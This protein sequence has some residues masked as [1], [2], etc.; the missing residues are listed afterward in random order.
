MGV[1]ASGSVA[2]RWCSRCFSPAPTAVAKASPAC[3]PSGSRLT[4]PPSRDRPPCLARATIVSQS[5]EPTPRRRCSG[6]TLI[7][8][9]PT[10]RF[11]LS[12]SSISATPMTVPS[13]TACQR[14]RS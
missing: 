1:G 12:G 5:A 6:S 13:S 8:H 3:G 10:S 2:T 11:S 9:E 14:A 4:S 7:S